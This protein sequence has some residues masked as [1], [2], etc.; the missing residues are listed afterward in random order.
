MGRKQ[1]VALVIGTIPIV[2]WKPRKI[3]VKVLVVVIVKIVIMV[4]MVVG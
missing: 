3:Q 4:V 2:A 1:V